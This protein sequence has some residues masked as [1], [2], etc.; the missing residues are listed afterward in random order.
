MDKMQKDRKTIE[1]LKAVIGAN[2]IEIEEIVDWLQEHTKTIE[3]L[4]K[5]IADLKG[6]IY[7]LKRN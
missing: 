3:K 7:S 6:Q 2:S 1:D 4:E 5:E